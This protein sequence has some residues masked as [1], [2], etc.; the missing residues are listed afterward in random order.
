[1][2]QNNLQEKDTIMKSTR[3][4]LKNLSERIRLVSGHPIIIEETASDFIVKLPLLT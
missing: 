2:V 1:V 4:E 3:T